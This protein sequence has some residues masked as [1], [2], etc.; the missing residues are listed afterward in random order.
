[1]RKFLLIVIAGIFFLPQVWNSY[2][3]VKAEVEKGYND[4]SDAD[5]K[6]NIHQTDSVSFGYDALANSIVLTTTADSKTVEVQIYK[7]DGSLIYEDKDCVEKGNSLIYTMRNEESGEYYVLVVVDEGEI[8]E[9]TII[10]E[11]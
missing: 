11:N 5:I 2:T 6:R 7:K 1:M 10:N 8:I 9:E 3:S 4:I